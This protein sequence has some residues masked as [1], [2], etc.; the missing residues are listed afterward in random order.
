MFSPKLTRRKFLAG[1][2]SAIAAMVGA[3]L[4]HVVFA[5]PSASTDIN[6]EVLVVVF[7]RGGWDALNVVLPIAGADRGYY[8][9]AREEIKIPV[10]GEGAAIPLNAQFGFHP[11]MAPLYDLYRQNS[12]AIVHAA[13]LHYD[14]R[15]HFD[16]MQYIELGTPGNKLTNTGWLTRH[17]Q[18]APNLP[19]AILFPSLSAGSQQASSLLGDRGAVAMSDP[20]NFDF[21]PEWWDYRDAQRTAMRNMYD[22]DTWLYEAGTRTLN[23]I[24]I[25]ENAS[26]GDYHPANGAVYPGGSFGDNL[27]TIAQMIKMN[28]GLRVATIDLGGWDT[29]EHQS[30]VL[31]DHLD[32]LARG[33]KAL[34]Q[35]LGGYTN[36][37][38]VVVMSEFG[39]RV[40]ENANYG[41]D[42]GHGGVMLVLGGHV[43]GGHIYGSWPGLDTAQLYDRADLAVTTD[44]RQVLSEIIDKR[45]E[46]PNLDVIFPGYTGY[47]PLGILQR[48]MIPTDWVYLPLVIR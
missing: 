37:L 12:L 18:T 11:A 26:P 41:T 14:T 13:G 44:Y 15:S 47:S 35:D 20:D 7:L 39:R 19:P 29:H 16:A 31:T 6:T 24:D 22:G 45:L 4:T 10:S 1:C 46:N 17:L 40:R 33:L 9:A 48:N 43:N 42:H 25:V 36:R 5:D 21:A 30:Y 3:K 8:E 38:T 23:A 2:S 32:D 28:L 34:Y 27:Q